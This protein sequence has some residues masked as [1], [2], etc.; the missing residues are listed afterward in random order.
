VV[1]ILIGSSYFYVNEPQFRASLN[2]VI[3]E[4]IQT[5]FSKNFKLKG[6][7]SERNELPF[8]YTS[9]A[10]NGCYYG[11]QRDSKDWIVALILP[12]IGLLT[13]SLLITFFSRR[14]GEYRIGKKAVDLISEYN[15][16]EAYKEIEDDDIQSPELWAK[17]FALSD[18]NEDRQQSVYV[19]L[20]ARQLNGR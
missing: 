8:I 11:S 15:Y 7:T 12:P 6:C 3:P 20:R 14:V 19:E 10:S 17:A 13:A 16:L 18:G 4:K 5:M 2:L 9:R 1:I